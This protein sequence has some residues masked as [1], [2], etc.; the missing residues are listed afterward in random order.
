MN[1]ANLSYDPWFIHFLANTTFDTNDNVVVYSD[2]GMIISCFV[3]GDTD[4]SGS[5][6]SIQYTL[7]LYNVLL[8]LFPILKTVHVYMYSVHTS[9]YTG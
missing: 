1:D 4:D 9:T 2:I 8:Y 3:N 6:G 5:G 7:L